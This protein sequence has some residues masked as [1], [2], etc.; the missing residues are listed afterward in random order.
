MSPGRS[1]AQGPVRVLVVTPQYLPDLGGIEQHVHATAT[2][3]ARRGDIALT[4]LATDRTGT[5]PVLADGGGFAVHRVR[6]Y[7]RHRDYYV[8]PGLGRVI[9]EGDFDLVHC[10]G[11]HTAVP[12][13]AMRAA[14]RAG[15]PYLVTLHTGGHSSGLRN[16]L[17]TAQ[18]RALGP[19]LRGAAAVV[20]VSRSERRLFEDTSRI[21]NARIHVIRNGGDL[22]TSPPPTDGARVPH[23]IVSSGRLERYKGHHRA[24]EALPLVRRSFPDATLRIL[25]AGPY[26]RALRQRVRALG[27]DQAI[28]ID[29]IEPGQRGA[30]AAALGG[31]G[32]FAALS[33][34]EGH[35]VAVMEA[36]TL[37]VPVV[38]LRT[39]GLVDL[40][41]DG[42][43]EGLAA[44]AGPDAVAGAL[45]A[46]LRAPRPGPPVGTPPVSLPSWNECADA[47]AGLYLELCGRKT[48]VEVRT[49]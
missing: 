21:D 1:P 13:L 43:I 23:Q 37:G 47:L 44:D 33:D 18:W 11:I 24:I 28:R 31:A 9:R 35:P 10:Q 41:E 8:A 49:G 22:S 6:A 14:R 15:L 4:V 19:W 32:V 46:A 5:R 38:G 39:P 20:A 25:G 48:G 42:L 12:V 34:Y 45:V 26:E 7:P 30:M 16:R 29:Y 27:L 36:L 3:I 17:R 40:A 2:R